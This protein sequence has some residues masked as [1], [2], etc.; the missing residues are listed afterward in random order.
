M[1]FFGQF[2]DHNQ[3]GNME[4]RQMTASFSSTFYALT[5]CKIHY[6]IEK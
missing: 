3:E 6:Y 2:K 1:P 5:V 4:T